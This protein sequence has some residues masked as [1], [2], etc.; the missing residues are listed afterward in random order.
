[1]NIKNLQKNFLA[2]RKLS[3]IAGQFIICIMIACVGLTFTFLGE[4]LSPGWKGS[5]LAWFFLAISVETIISRN[6]TRSLEGRDKWI[7]LA[8]EFILIAILIKILL[9]SLY[10][11]SQILS[12]VQRWEADLSSFFSLEFLL[13]VL[14]IFSARI[15]CGRLLADFETLQSDAED[16]YSENIGFMEKDRLSTHQRFLETVLGTGFATVFITAL[17]RAQMP[18]QLGIPDAWQA[19]VFNVVV[20][21]VLALILLSQSQFAMLHGRWLWQRTPVSPG[22]SRNW[23]VYTLVFFAILGLLILLLPTHYS[24]QLLYALEVVFS[25]IYKFLLFLLALIAFFI[26]WLFSLFSR[27]NPQT[28]PE[29]MAPPQFSQ[30]Q[31][32]ATPPTPLP[33]LETVRAVVFWVIFGTILVYA[34]RTYVIKNSLLI[35]TLGRNSLIAWLIGGLKSIWSWL[36][37]VNRQVSATLAATFQKGRSMLGASADSETSEFSN[38]HSLLPRQKVI[39]YYL[40]LVRRSTQRGLPRKLNQTPLQFEET[41][42]TSLP[43]VEHEIDALTDSFVEARY[44]KHEIDGEK[45]NLLQDFWKRVMTTLRNWQDRS[46]PG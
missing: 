24:L 13:D 10:G 31:P 35:S 4:R 16:V 21:F 14:L 36:L 15:L 34:I 18:S 3:F 5:Y 33:W 22:L 6:T 42:R 27:P 40:T 30:I 41:L 43:E 45:V 2:N 7:F 12:D 32:A 1:V 23:I 19:P 26:T 46:K 11:F 8:S 28:P 39:F 17:T 44:S 9:Y 37:G 38:P 29:A 20:Y 25:Y